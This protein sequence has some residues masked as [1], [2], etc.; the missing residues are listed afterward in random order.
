VSKLI[1]IRLLKL[2]KIRSSVR[3]IKIGQ[4]NFFAILCNEKIFNLQKYA[5]S[6]KITP[7]KYAY[8]SASNEKIMQTILHD[9]SSK[10]KSNRR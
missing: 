7:K 4:G 6:C 8:I 10:Q 1:K 5:I 9:S 3:F 2:I